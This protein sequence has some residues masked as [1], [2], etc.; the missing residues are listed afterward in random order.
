VQNALKIAVFGSDRSGVSFY[1][2]IDPANEI[3]RQGLME[4]DSI[5]DKMLFEPL[6]EKDDASPYQKR[7]YARNDEK[8]RE[9]GE[10]ADMM[11]SIRY[12]HEEQGALLHVLAYKFGLPW[13]VDIDDDIF[14]LNIENPMYDTYRQRDPKELFDLREITCEDDIQPGEMAYQDEYGSLVAVKLK[15]R[16]AY[17]ICK[18]Q[19]IDCDA[20]TVSTDVLRDLYIDVR[21]QAGQN[22]DV[23]VVPNS[24]RLR[25]WDACPPGP[26][27]YPEVWVGWQGGSSHA[28]DLDLVCDV[29][30]ALL[31][32]HSNMRFLWVNLP[33]QGLF[34]LIQRHPG[35]VTFLEGWMPINRYHDYYSAMNFD[36]ALAPLVDNTFNRGKS[37]LK[38][39]EAGAR[40]QACICSNVGPYKAQ[41]RNWKDGVLVPNTKE[42][43][44]DAIDKLVRE[45]SLREDIGK[46]ARRR[47]EKD[48]CLEKNVHRRAAVYQEIYD[49]HAERCADRQDMMKPKLEEAVA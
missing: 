13:V 17:T 5:N 31:K 35:K 43:W 44:Y 3:T 2:I 24:I 15:E 47:V 4:V 28:A 18:H 20:M 39:M 27:H 9:L 29:V 14:N 8:Y 11:T 26:D 16:D 25:E 34:E 42:A 21:R 22:D 12:I 32:K 1:R 40:R 38:W 33:H 48:F 41:V 37:S 46:R 7:R 45:R 30:D 36:I 19:I 10:W 6:L 49:K 23:Y